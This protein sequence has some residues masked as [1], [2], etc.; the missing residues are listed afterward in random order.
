MN[1]ER[2]K[3]F[4]GKVVIVAVKASKE[5]SKTA[6]LWAL[7]CIVESGDCIKLIAVL[8]SQSSGKR[9]W[10]FPK[11]GMD[12]TPGK[13]NWVSIS[14]GRITDEEC[15]K[16]ACSQMV[17]LLHDLYD[18]EK[19]KMKVKVISG[20]YGAVAEEAK[21][22]PCSWII[23]DK[24][25]KKEAPPCIEQLR[26]N[27][28]IM[29]RCRPKILRLNLVG[30]SANNPERRNLTPNSDSLS[31]W[32]LI[33]APN[34]TPLN[35]PHDTPFSTTDAGT[36][37]S[38]S[39]GD[40]GKSP[41]SVSEINRERKR[42]AFL[43]TV[44]RHNNSNIDGSEVSSEEFNSPSTSLCSPSWI[45]ATT[46]TLSSDHKKMNNNYGLDLDSRKAPADPPPLC[47]LCHHKA[48]VFG[49]PP[50]WFSYAELEHATKG[51]SEANF[52]AEGGFGSVHRGFLPDGQIVA[53]KQYKLESMQGDRE[54][55]S[56]IEVLSCAQ[57]RNVV[58]LIGLCVEDKKRL[59]VY[60]YICNGSL[61]THLYGDKKGILE[62]CSRQRIAVGA[63]R[64]L[65]YLHEE[66]R[67]GCIVHRDVRPNNILITHDFEP[68][69][70]DFGLARWQPDGDLG[71][72][73]RIIGRFGYLAPE[74]AQSG[75]ITEKADV[76]SF[77]MVLLELVTGRKAMDIAR[78]RG[79]Q[80]LSEWARPLLKKLAIEELI[81]PRI[82]NQ[83]SEQEVIS[84][85]HCAS[86]CIRRAPQSRP[87]MSQVLRMLEG[88]TI[89]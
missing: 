42:L 1:N 22:A 34:L 88:D 46:T 33:Q 7:T 75:Q 70:G 16:E 35:S 8:P 9:L 32:N 10:V 2:E 69:V 87:R 55:C 77:G 5:I 21:K 23:L 80:C 85:L 74:Y 28:A 76:Y 68:L 65:R 78:P 38:L 40:T 52:L 17:F 49:K 4:K 39:S 47:S 25:L 37:S 67:V 60:E 13:C 45:T 83:C 11:L 62:W 12:W 41:F 36:A 53:V 73:T 30:S 51:F 18:S 20:S 82:R 63:A 56:E 58:M 84:M 6:L 15:I 31:L 14:M 57:H 29:K 3:I 64:G 26:C 43:Q 19:I 59:L 72:E 81:D 61:D 89:S 50:R 79:Q 44:D 54:F 66:C 27:I 48:P 24:G 86:L 71:V